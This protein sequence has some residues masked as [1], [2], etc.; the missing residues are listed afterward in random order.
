MQVS[1]SNCTDYQARRLECRFGQAS[2]KKQQGQNVKAYVHM[3]NA[4]LTATER[5]LC[6]LVEN[7]QT[8]KGEC[9][10]CVFSRRRAIR[11]PTLQDQIILHEC[12]CVTFST[13]IHCSSSAYTIALLCIQ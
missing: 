4:T 6:C 8:D 5:T 13:A 3:L 9:L 7:Y 2:Q 10:A 1:C 12:T 11:C